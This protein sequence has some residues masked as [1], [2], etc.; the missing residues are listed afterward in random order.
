DVYSLDDGEHLWGQTLTD[1][2]PRA[3]S[4]G[5]RQTQVLRVQS[6]LVI[7]DMNAVHVFTPGDEAS[8]SPD[9]TDEP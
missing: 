9:E 5:G 2:R 4:P 7:A 6:A 1:V 3:T 8:P